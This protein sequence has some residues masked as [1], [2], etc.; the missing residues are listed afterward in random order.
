MVVYTIMI[1]CVP[2]KVQALVGVL[3]I[4]IVGLLSCLFSIFGTLGCGVLH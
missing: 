1:G 3:L 4:D 2:T